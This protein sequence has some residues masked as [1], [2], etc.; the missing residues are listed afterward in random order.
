MSA[1]MIMKRFL[2]A[3][4]LFVPCVGLWTAIESAVA[5]PIDEPRSTDVAVSLFNGKDLTGWDSLLGPAEKGT[6]PLGKNHDVKNVF[7]VVELD[8]KPAIRVSGQVWG[9]LT[10]RDEFE[11]YHLRVEFKWGQ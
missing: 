7:S 3:C 11:N 1:E 8:G 6:P 10:T 5:A 2:F 4:V 9:G